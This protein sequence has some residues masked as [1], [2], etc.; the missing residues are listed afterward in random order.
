MDRTAVRSRSVVRRSR[1][2][3]RTLERRENFVS[4]QF[5]RLLAGRRDALRVYP[6]YEFVRASLFN[7]VFDLVDNLLGC[8]SDKRIL[9]NVRGETVTEFVFDQPLCVVVDLLTRQSIFA[10]KGWYA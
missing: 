9:G 2:A 3:V 10:A 8:A 7:D 6:K 1:S 4:E 5:E